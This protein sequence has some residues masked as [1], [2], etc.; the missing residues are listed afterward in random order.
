MAKSTKSPGRQYPKPYAGFPLS[1]HTHTNRWYKTIKGSRRYFGPLDDWKAALARYEHEAPYWADGATPPPMGEKPDT[2]KS[3]RSVINAFMDAKARQVEAGDMTPRTLS[4]YHSVAKVIAA[5]F[6]TRRSIDTLTPDDFGKLRAVLAKRHASPTTLGNVITRCRSIFKWAVDNGIT[7][8]ATRYG[9]QF[10]KP[11]RRAVKLARRERAH[12]FFE[13]AEVRAMLDAADTTT[14]AIVLLG[15]NAGLGNDDISNL[16]ID[17]LDLTAGVLDLYRRKTGE[18]RRAALWSETVEAVAES[19]HAGPEPADEADAGRV[20]VTTHGKPMV[21][22]TLHDDK[23]LR[24][25]RRDNVSQRFTK[26][27]DAAGVKGDGRGFYALRH[28][29][30]SVADA[31]PDRPAVDL[32]MGHESSADIRTAYVDPR[33]ISVNRLRAVSAHVHGW[34]WPRRQKGGKPKKK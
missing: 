16:T 23:G 26:L 9:T 13:A 3:V 31:V 12:Q 25:V 14:R 30:R 2:A 21:H 4:E 10:G 18:E 28:T 33:S 19:L 15:I 11:K 34:L 6:G 8:K 24:H 22:T 20:F 17:D 5:T 29:Y 7:D 32:T 27:R 1:A